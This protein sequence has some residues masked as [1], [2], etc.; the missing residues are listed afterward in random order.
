MD[1]AASFSWQQ[2]TMT[3]LQQLSH[4]LTHQTLPAYNISASTAQK[5][6]ILCC[7]AIVAVD[8]GLFVEPLLG[9]GCCIV[10]YLVAVA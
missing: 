9:N 2:L 5:T 1:S 4:T 8:T 6:P 3:E 10:A 7:Y